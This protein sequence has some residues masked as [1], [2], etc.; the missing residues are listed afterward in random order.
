MPISIEE[1]KDELLEQ[2]KNDLEILEEF[3]L[4]LKQQI[5]LEE[6][7]EADHEVLET[8]IKDDLESGKEKVAEY[9]N[10]LLSMFDE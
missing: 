4:L 6:N 8:V 2:L 10:G 1:Q 5:E 9:I 3:K 7:L